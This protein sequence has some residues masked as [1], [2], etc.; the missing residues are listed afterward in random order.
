M[1]EV[2]TKNAQSRGQ[3]DFAQ[4]F[5]LLRQRRGPFC[6]GLDP[7]PEL[8]NGWG[9]ADGVEGLR[10]FCFTVLDAAADQLTAI[11]PQSAYFERFGS[12]GI[13]VLEECLEAIR[14]RESLALLDVKRGDIGSTNQAYAEAYLDARSP[15]KADA[16]TVHPYLGFLA[17]APFVEQAS[18]S[19]TGLFVVVLSSN[20]EGRAIQ[21]ARVSSD[22]SVVQSLCD[23]IRDYNR[24]VCPQS[25][26]P[27]GAV[28]GITAEQAEETVERLAGSLILAPGLGAQGG[29]FAQ[30]GKRF[31][32]A[33]DRVLPASSRAV[34][35]Q[36]PNLKPLRESIKQHREK[37]WEALS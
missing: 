37:S 14:D 30:L 32:R 25:T 17:L 6:L 7:S 21:N 18:L 28:V 31:E 4:R 23:A 11:K 2:R 29:E 12:K 34:L 10:R 8:L 35:S 22:T 5:A 1:S 16:I 36:G 26:G 15:L 27:I 3:S 33:K 19:Q 24:S 20:P 9:L 13:A